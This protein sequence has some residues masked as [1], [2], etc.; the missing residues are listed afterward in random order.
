MKSIK[1]QTL[2]LVAALFVV[3]AVILVAFFGVK[4]FENSVIRKQDDALAISEENDGNYIVYN[5]KKY[6]KKEGITTILLIGLDENGEMKESESYNNSSQS[7]FLTLLVIDDTIRKCNIIQL[8]RDTMTDISVLG[9]AGQKI[10][11]TKAQLAL[12]HT[13]G[14]GLHDSCRNTVSAVKNLIFD[15]EIDHY[16]CVNMDAVEALNDLVGG[17]PV[18]VLDDFGSTDSTLIKGQTVTL[19]GEHALNYVRGR[20]NVGNQT[21]ISRMARQKQ[22]MASFASRLKEAYKKDGNFVLRMYNAIVK[23]MVSD[24]SVND[25]SSASKQLSEYIIGDIIIPEGES[26]KGEEFMEFYVDDDAL[27]STI[28]SLYFNEIEQ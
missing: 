24:C 10:G 20:I 25:F 13:Y 7:D 18:E 1:G 12:A 6:A 2:K 22:Y 28:I 8:N 21:N 27:K 23:Y 11:K 4:I 15:M 14:N 5:G 16:I 19:K 3:I 9:V 17:V 26:V